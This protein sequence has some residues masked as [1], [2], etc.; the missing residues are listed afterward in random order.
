MKKIIFTPLE[1]PAACSG[2]V[3]V[4]MKPRDEWGPP[5]LS[6]TEPPEHNWLEEVTSIEEQ[7][8]DALEPE[9]IPLSFEEV[10]EKIGEDLEREGDQSVLSEREE[11]V[12]FEIVSESSERAEDLILKILDQ[13]EAVGNGLKLFPTLRPTLP[14]PFPW[15]ETFRASIEAYEPWA[16]DMFSD[17][18]K[19]RR[20]EEG[21]ETPLHS[22]LTLLVHARFEQKGES[23]KALENTRRVFKQIAQP[24]LRF[25]DI[26]L[27]EG[28]PFSPGEQWRD[29]FHRAFPKIVETAKRI[30]EKKV[31]RAEDLE[32]LIQ[33]IPHMGNQ[34]S[35]MAVRWIK[36]FIPEEV[37]EIDFSNARV[38][39]EESLYRVVAR[40]GV[41]DPHFDLYQGINSMADL[42][43]QSFAKAVFPEYPVKIER[44][45]TWV[46]R[47]EE[48]GFCLPIQPR[49][50]GCPCE[51][52]CP[53]HYLHFNPSEKGMKEP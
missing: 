3:E 5:S 27:L 41:V 22:L 15:L 8:L 30:H 19:T 12:S 48:G 14:P 18:F 36:A 29:L 53:K 2:W 38:Q 34:N 28:T 45:L 51:A 21:F 1:S 50:E 49:C 11:V 42:K 9:P 24:D 35:R 39:I 7:R 43:I 37:L 44:P 40:L 16:H 33:I 10:E 6:V 32:R 31:W 47:A 25:E 26:P 20:D 23:D 4:E 46:G 17:W 13:D 52:F